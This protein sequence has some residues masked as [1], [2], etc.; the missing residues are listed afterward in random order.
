MP[1]VEEV[2]ALA[3][4]AV[5]TSAD[6]PIGIPQAGRWVEDR[7]R[8]LV[9]KVR[10]R[11]LRRVAALDIPPAIET[12][13]LTAVADSA[14]LVADAAAVAA[15][16]A[17]GHTIV[18]YHV[19]I[20]TV[21]YEITA[22]VA[23][24][25]TI[26]TPFSELPLNGV[27]TVQSGFKILPRFHDLDPS[28]RWLGKFVYPKRRRALQ[29]RGAQDFDRTAPERMLTADGPWFVAEATNNA[30]TRGKRVELYPYNT[31]EVTIY[32]TYWAIPAVFTLDTIL[33]QEVDAYVLREGVLV[34]VYRYRMSQSIN[35]GKVEE[36]GFWRRFAYP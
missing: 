11:H 14:T 12:G 30:T 16:A 26:A 1:T 34:D 33:P 2:A 6:R 20:Y 17:S 28:A 19:R 15:I 29:M 5:D 27:T 22:Y 13:T 21:W 4:A 8:E 7:Y 31:I 3:L 10:F 36:A 24:N 32:Y 25:I 9:A 18:G 23:P 35:A